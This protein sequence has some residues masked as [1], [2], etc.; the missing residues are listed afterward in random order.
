MGLQEM[1]SPLL[2]LLLSLMFIPPQASLPAD[3]GL[4]SR[5]QNA[6]CIHVEITVRMEAIAQSVQET[7]RPVIALQTSWVTSASTVSFP[8]WQTLKNLFERKWRDIFVVC[9]CEQEA[10]KATAWTK[11]RVCRGITAPRCAAVLRS[12]PA[13]HARSTGVTTVET[14]PASPVME[15][16]PQGRSPA[17]RRPYWDTSLMWLSNIW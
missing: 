13:A 9:L 11:E 15:F 5:G 14:A 16:L 4:A 3:A 7:S 1:L 2:S 8:L 10:V 17:G 12:S 6:T